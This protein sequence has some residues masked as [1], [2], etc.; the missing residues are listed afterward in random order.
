MGGLGFIAGG[1]VGRGGMDL[2]LGEIMGLDPDL[3]RHTAH[4]TLEQFSFFHILLY[5]IHP[6]K[7][8]V[9]NSDGGL[10]FV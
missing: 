10:Q 9:Q 4:E 1:L 5:K 3:L 7:K 8:I 2:I 6:L